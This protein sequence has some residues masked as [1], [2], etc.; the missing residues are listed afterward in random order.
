MMPVKIQCGCGQRYAFDIE[1]FCG[2][3]PFPVACPVCGADGTSAAN[4][5][6]AFTLAIELS[7]HHGGRE[8]MVLLAVLGCLVAGM[9]GVIKASTMASGLDVLLCLWGSVLA[10]GVAIGVYLWKHA[11]HLSGLAKKRASAP[12]GRAPVNRRFRV[13]I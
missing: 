7:A 9:V 8:R 4:E 6:I 1:P 3:M 13:A 11:H 5:V 10:F 12:A 2:R